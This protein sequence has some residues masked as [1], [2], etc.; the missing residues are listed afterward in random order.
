MKIKFLLVSCVFSC[1][2]AYADQKPSEEIHQSYNHRINFSPSTLGYEHI[3]IDGLYVGA[4]CL[5]LMEPDYSGDLQPF[6]GKAE[7][8]VGYNFSFNPS[9]TLTPFVGGGYFQSFQSFK[10]SNQS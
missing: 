3:K 4:E 7:A 9:N 1:L 2:A 6:F 5:Y 8:R 10:L